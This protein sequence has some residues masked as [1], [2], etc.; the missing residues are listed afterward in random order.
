MRS[1]NEDDAFDPRVRPKHCS[2]NNQTVSGVFS[3]KAF[4][5][6]PQTLIPHCFGHRNHLVVSEHPTHAVAYHYI[7]LMVRIKLVGFGQ[8]FP[9]SQRG[10]EDRITSWIRKDPELVMLADLRIGL[11]SIDRLRPIK[12]C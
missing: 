3:E 10:I 9:Q 8:F 4:C 11:E 12:W 1:A 2:V 7:R 5:S 6:L